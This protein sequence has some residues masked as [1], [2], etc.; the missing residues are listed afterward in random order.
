MSQHIPFT[1]KIKAKDNEIE[2]SGSKED[3]MD[4]L[5]NI[6]DIM[7]KV[8]RTFTNPSPVQSTLQIPQTTSKSKFPSISVSPDTPCPDTILKLLATEWGREKPRKLRELLE[9]MKVNAIHY[10]IGT[11]KG[12]LTDMTKK[13]YL[14]RVREGREYAYIRVK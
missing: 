14:R 1:I 2:L 11:V 9:A 8:T 12:R 5:N 3:V 7:T 4:A 6:N 10:P 13:G